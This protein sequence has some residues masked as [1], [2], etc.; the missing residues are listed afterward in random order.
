MKSQKKGALKMFVLTRLFSF[1]NIPLRHYVTYVVCFSI[2]ITSPGLN[3]LALSQNTSQ[4]I[5]R[6][7]HKPK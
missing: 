4:P 1:K 7:P 3:Y 6:Q 2:C 5:G